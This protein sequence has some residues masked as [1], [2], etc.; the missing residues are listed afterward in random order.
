MSSE[1]RAIDFLFH[2]QRFHSSSWSSH[3]VDL[4]GAMLAHYGADGAEV[5]LQ[6]SLYGSER[7][8][9]IVQ[10]QDLA[11][12]HVFQIASYSR[13]ASHLKRLK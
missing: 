7:C 4:S 8:T 3:F 9:G 6:Q 2:Q 13:I 10:P 5:G 12:L 11:C 1:E